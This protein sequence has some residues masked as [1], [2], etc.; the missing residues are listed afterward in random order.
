MVNKIN[1]MA[2][3]GFTYGT[4][5]AF[6]ATRDYSQLKELGGQA[7]GG[8]ADGEQGEESRMINSPVINSLI[9]F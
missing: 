5:G 9:L 2:I 4:A 8:H 3:Q 6:M 1:T 7:D